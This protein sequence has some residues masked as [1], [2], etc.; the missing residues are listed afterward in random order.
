MH[1]FTKQPTEILEDVVYMRT[2]KVHVEKAKIFAEAKHFS[3]YCIFHS[4]ICGLSQLVTF[5]FS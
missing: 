4:S 5:I 1:L 2:Q 3:F